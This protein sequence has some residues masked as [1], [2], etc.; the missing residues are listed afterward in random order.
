MENFHTKPAWGHY[1]K[2]LTEFVIKK[3]LCR[4]DALGHYYDIG[5]EAKN[6]KI[7]IEPNQL[8]QKLLGHF[9]GGD[10]RTGFYSYS[11][12]GNC[13][14]ICIDIDAHNEVVTGNLDIALSICKQLRRWGINPILEDTNGKGGYHLW[15]LFGEPV[16]VAI[17]RSIGL[18]L[19]R[20]HAGHEVFPKQS[21]VK[22]YGSYVRLPG[23]HHKNI[24]W[25]S[26]FYDFDKSKFLGGAPGID[27][28]LYSEP[29]S[30]D[31]VPEVAKSFKP[32]IEKK[33]ILPNSNANLAEVDFSAYSGDIKTLNIRELCKDRLTGTDRGYWSDIVCPWC[34]SH[35]T[36]DKIAA[37]IQSD[38]NDWPGFN[39]F[40]NHCS[41]KKLIDLLGCYPVERVN[42]CCSGRFEAHETI[43]DVDV[44]E[45]E[46]SMN[47]EVETNKPTTTRPAD[48][49]ESN[50]VRYKRLAKDFCRYYANRYLKKVAGILYMWDGKKY[51]VVKELEDR[52]RQFCVSIK[53]NQTNSLISNVCPIIA[54][55]GYVP[56]KNLPFWDG[57]S[58]P[59][60]DPKNVISFSNGLLDIEK[61]ENGIMPLTHQWVSTFSLPFAFEPKATCPT[62]LNFLDSVFPVGTDRQELLQEYM[63]YCLTQD[64]SLHKAMI[65]IGKSRAGKGVIQTMMTQLVGEE[66][67]TGY[68]LDKLA[69]DFGLSVLVG[70]TLATVPEVELS[71]KD[72]Q[73]IIEIFKGIVGGDP[74]TI[75]KKH[76][77]EMPSVRLSTRFLIATN[78]KP[79]L[80]DSSGATA[81]RLLFIPFEESFLGKED[82]Q[83]TNKLAKELPGIA[84]WALKGLQRLRANGGVFTTGYH[85]QKTAD[86]YAEETSPIIAW[87]KECTQISS[88]AS[89]GDLPEDCVSSDSELWT[90]KQ[91]SYNNYAL[92]AEQRHLPPKSA[93]WFAR[94]L[95]N[96]LPKLKDSKRDSS[97]GSTVNIWKGLGLKD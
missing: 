3:M 67:A 89:S 29:N 32:V 12:Q 25:Y 23:R 24:N 93:N 33:E 8:R 34:E 52:L 85:H 95:K 31:L 46:Q 38:E 53:E 14:W 68:S 70:K 80:T 7:D 86:S 1:S 76:Q 82:R 96:V 54:N 63:G 22:D 87:L 9:N 79:M 83:L 35:T 91:Q 28:F 10:Y 6:C 27:Q 61:I 49:K 66:N 57:E 94:D 20:D 26:E 62:W 56:D 77:A 18:Y 45:F 4:N 90:E 30:L 55:S 19:T 81:N 47:D 40:H 41:E 37:I 51:V 21:V 64:T 39:C 50:E 84:I 75:N 11:K 92:W 42:E 48:K 13:R 59:F 5:P 15:V 60:S 73:K 65:L 71:G 58:M 44:P 97:S 2:E 72:R 16:P 17:A 36:D 69:T 88:W 43:P 74:Q 78:Q